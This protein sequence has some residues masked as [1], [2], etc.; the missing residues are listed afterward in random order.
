MHDDESLGNKERRDRQNPEDNVRG[1]GLAFPLFTRTLS[2][3]ATTSVTLAANG[4][5][6]LRFAVP[7]SGDALLTVTQ[8]GQAMPS[9]IMLS[10]VR[11]K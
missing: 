4:V 1:A 10:V 3:N 11:V 8:N 7:N 9:T 5:S 2:D 6:F